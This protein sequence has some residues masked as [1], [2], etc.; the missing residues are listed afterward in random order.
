MKSTKL[1]IILSLMWA[2]VLLLL[3]GWWLY[4]MT[5]IDRIMKEVDPARFSKMVFWEGS[6]FIAL[7][8]LLSISLF[9]FYLG[10]QKKTQALQDFFA[11]LTHELKTPLASIKL[12]GEVIT[13]YFSDPDLRQNDQELLKL[14]H[15][16]TLDTYKLE[17]QMDKILQL[18]RLER[19]G[20]LNLS[21]ID[22]ISFIE[23]VYLNWKDEFTLEIDHKGLIEPHV[24]ADEF[25]LQMILKNL[26]ENTKIHAKSQSVNIQISAIKNNIILNYRDEG[27]FT[28]HGHKIGTLFYKHNSGKGS[29][30]GL[31]LTKKLMQKMAGDLTFIPANHFQLEL[32]FKNAEDA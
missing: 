19:G 8:F 22:L 12:Q 13:E 23:N 20:E 14:L 21:S 31:Y 29:G 24:L 27:K 17:I 5:N 30:I 3:G 15:R 18:S 32:T 6:T 10:D 28:G 2:S 9:L 25:A 7:L 11:S 4:L 1:Q 26:F 16:L